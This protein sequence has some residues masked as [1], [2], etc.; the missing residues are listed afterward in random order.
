MADVYIDSTLRNDWNVKFNPQLCDDLEEKGIPCYLP[1]R[2][3]NQDS[4]HDSIF[5]ENINGIKNADILLAIANNES[6]NWGVELGYAYGLGKKIVA[7]ATTVHD[8]P[9]LAKYMINQVITAEDI[10]NI[11]SYINELVEALK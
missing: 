11:P 3:T 7:L 6:P 10:D 4:T 1:Q 9:L 8:I 5:Q 2:D